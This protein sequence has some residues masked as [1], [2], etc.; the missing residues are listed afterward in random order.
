MDIY[1]ERAHL[2]A[3]LAQRYP[4]V[5]VFGADSAE[6]DWPVLFIHAAGAGQMTWHIS[7]SGVDLFDNVSQRHQG[8]AGAP[9][10]DGHSTE[11]K[12]ERLRRLSTTV[13]PSMW[14]TD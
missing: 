8:D 5:L 11:V 14:G 1:R 2:L 3:H 4:S 13:T 10:W 9:A 6:P 7:P 12:Y